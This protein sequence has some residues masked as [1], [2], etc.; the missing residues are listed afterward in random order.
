MKNE[1][2][3]ALPNLTAPVI[4]EPLEMQLERREFI[5][6]FEAQEH[7]DD[8]CP[9]ILVCAYAKKSNR[10]IYKKGNKKLQQR[11]ENL[12]LNGKDG[13]ITELI[14]T[15]MS[16]GVTTETEGNKLTDQ[17]AYADL[18][19]RGMKSIYG[20]VQP[21]TKAQQQTIIDV[22]ILNIEDTRKVYNTDVINSYEDLE[23]H[24]RKLKLIDEDIEDAD[25]EEV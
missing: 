8:N 13:M 12:W 21:D 11:F 17:R 19:M 5:K 25:F 14:N 6:R 3:I 20:D 10:C 15:M 16:V 24:K 1:T 4:A 23:R 9:V 22:K 7:C 2:D 18:L